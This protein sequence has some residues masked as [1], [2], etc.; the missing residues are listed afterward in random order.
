MNRITIMNY[1]REDQ[2]S[3][4]KLPS[5]TKLVTVTRRE[6]G[7]IIAR[8]FPNYCFAGMRG[9]KGNRPRVRVS[10]DTYSQP[11]GRLLATCLTQAT[12]SGFN[13]RVI[14]S[15]KPGYHFIRSGHELFCKSYDHSVAR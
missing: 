9:L 5:F 12:V 6:L 7:K 8:T 10:S 13:D 3:N 11:R 4:R 15:G 2:Q 14:V 1:V